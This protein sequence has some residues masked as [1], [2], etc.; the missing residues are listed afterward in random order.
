MDDAAVGSSGAA[1][2]SA[3][4]AQ[5]LCD[6]REVDAVGGAAVVVASDGGAVVAA[7]AAAAVLRV[8]S[9]RQHLDEIFVACSYRC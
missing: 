3:A 7:A 4:E 6:H 2:V 8:P 1:G 9:V 5:Q